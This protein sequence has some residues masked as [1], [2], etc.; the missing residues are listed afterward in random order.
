MISPYLIKQITID[1]LEQGYIL[2]KLYDLLLHVEK[3]FD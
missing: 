3:L 1:F 2:R